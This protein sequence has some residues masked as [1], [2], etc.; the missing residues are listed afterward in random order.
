MGDEAAG[1]AAMEKMMK[2]MAEGKM[3]YGPGK[4]TLI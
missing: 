1:E 4:K 3:P 2:A